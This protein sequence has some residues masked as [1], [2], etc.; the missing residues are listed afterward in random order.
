MNRLYLSRDVY[1]EDSVKKTCFV[2]REYA[3]IKFKLKN[4]HIELSFDRC[5]YDPDLTMKEFENY[6]I[7][8]ENLKK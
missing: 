4:S 7:G 6:L 1:S 5:K 8:V 2:Y 3:Q